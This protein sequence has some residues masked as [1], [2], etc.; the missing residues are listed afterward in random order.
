MAY[1]TL[2]EECA[3][4]HDLYTRVLG[5]PMAQVDV[6]GMLTTGPLHCAQE[7]GWGKFVRFESETWAVRSAPAGRIGQ[8][9]EPGELRQVAVL[10]RDKFSA[11]VTLIKL[12]RGPPNLGLMHN[13]RDDRRQQRGARTHGPMGTAVHAIHFFQDTEPKSTLSAVATVFGD[14]GLCRVEASMSPHYVLCGSISGYVIPGVP[15]T[16]P[17]EVKHTFDTWE[18]TSHTFARLVKSMVSDGTEAAMLLFSSESVLE[19]CSFIGYLDMLA[20]PFYEGALPDHA[21]QPNGIALM[22]A[23]A[24]RI[25]CNPAKWNLPP[26][27]AEDAYATRETNLLAESTVPSLLGTDASFAIDVVI[28]RAL[29]EMLV[30]ITKM[31]SGKL[32]VSR[33]N[34]DP[35]RIDEV[36]LRPQPQPARLP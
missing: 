24:V 26:T 7:A 3:T 15:R 1:D 2:E 33:I 17:C 16:I 35:V 18:Q 8:P 30:L 36:L 13:E 28:S 25:A 6:C 21:H 23:I 12:W 20:D 27:R 10:V 32:D 14:S 4:I 31:Q 22:M 34:A 9:M 5:L 19:Q 11:R 29:E